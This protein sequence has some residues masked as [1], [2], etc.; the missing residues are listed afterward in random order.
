MVEG[1]DERLTHTSNPRDKRQLIIKFTEGV[2]LRRTTV[3]DSE[4]QPQP[5]SMLPGRFGSGLR[6]LLT[7]IGSIPMIV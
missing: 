1:L 5:F 4:H 2:R 7:H 6:Q 3:G